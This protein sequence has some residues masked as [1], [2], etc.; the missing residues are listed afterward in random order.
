MLWCGRIP[1]FRRTLLSPFSAE[2]H[3]NTLRRHNPARPQLES[4]SP[5]EPQIPNGIYKSVIYYTK[6]ILVIVLC[7]RYIWKLPHIYIYMK[8][9]SRDSSVGIATGYG[10]DDRMIWVRF[11]AEAGKFSLRHR[12]QTGF[13][14]QRASYPMGSGESSSGGKATGAWSWPPT[15]I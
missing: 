8:L 9:K 6:I 15:S 14:A 4:S 10:L 11:S 13:G 1:K 5:C 12:V 7:L 3:R 2:D